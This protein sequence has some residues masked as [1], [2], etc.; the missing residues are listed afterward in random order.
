MH[1]VLASFG[2]GHD[3]ILKISDIGASISFPPG[4]LIMLLSK[5]FEHSADWTMGERICVPHFM[6]DEVHEKFG[7]SVPILPKLGD[8]LSLVGPKNQVSRKRKY[9]N[10]D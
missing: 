5:V 8:Y 3:A 2:I 9:Q 4:S 6:K 1:D 10:L 7:M